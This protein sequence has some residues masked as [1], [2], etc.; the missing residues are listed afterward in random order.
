M[1]SEDLLSSVEYP[2]WNGRAELGI[3]AVKH[4]IYDST[5]PK[6]SLDNDKAAKAIMKYQNKPLPDLSLSPAQIL[7]L[8]NIIDISTHPPHYELHKEWV[9]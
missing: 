9:I 7:F 4:I 5:H 6:G 1:G 2:Q 3:K 8:G